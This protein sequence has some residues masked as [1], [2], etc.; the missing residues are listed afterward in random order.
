MERGI[1]FHMM[2]IIDPED[3]GKRSA[4]TEQESSPD[5]FAFWQPDHGESVG[6]SRGDQED[7]SR[8]YTSGHLP[9]NGLTDRDGHAA[10]R[11]ASLLRR[12]ETLRG[13]ALLRLSSPA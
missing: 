2:T 4:Q 12:V 7:A 10:D 8:R 11:P 9:D 1:F 5:A 13:D 3:F 6:D